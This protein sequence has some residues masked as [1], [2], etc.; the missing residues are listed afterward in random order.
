MFKLQNKLY[1]T[2]QAKPQGARN[3]NFGEK[4]HQEPNSYFQFYDS[5]RC[6]VQ[7]HKSLNLQ[8]K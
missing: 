6:K 4:L 7:G 8:L 2:H 5:E 1:P 3:Y